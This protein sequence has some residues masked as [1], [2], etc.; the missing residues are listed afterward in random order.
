[1]LTTIK[2]LL[3][4]G[5]VLVLGVF[6][7][8]FL[9]VQDITKTSIYSI[10]V[11][12]LLAIGLY[13]SVYNISIK[14]FRSNRLIVGQAITIGVL[15]KIL[16]IGGF[17]YI[18]T[19]NPIALLLGVTVAQIDPLSVARLL[20]NEETRLSKNAQSILGAWASFD[21]P[22]TVLASVYIVGIITV[23]TET[24]SSAYFGIGII[25]YLSTFG[26]NI[27]LAAIIYILHRL[28]I[29]HKYTTYLLLFPS[30]II[31]IAFN[32]FL[33]I[34]IIGL[35]IRPK[36]NRILPLLVNISLYS[37]ILVLGLLVGEGVAF[38]Q[39]LILAFAATLAQ[40]IA[41]F[42]VIGS[43]S[44][45]DRFHLAFSQ[46]NGI[47]AIILALLFEQSLPG[48]VAIVAPAIFLINIGHVLLNILVDKHLEHRQHIQV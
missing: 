48:I 45:Q 32:L 2:W 24:A 13:G 35:F 23:P 9:E 3:S 42:L 11:Y 8:N 41:G 14:E 27:I 34:A 10:F 36:I 29:K 18:F 21:D 43:L 40:I 30:F 37:S 46:Q 22:V 15:F 6:L 47:T 31:A 7:S 33:A 25:R 19:N 16:F 17:F 4:T 28:F 39:G 1:M 12:T 26:L 5:L 44:R 20:N 38:V